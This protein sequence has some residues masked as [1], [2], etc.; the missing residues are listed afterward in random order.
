MVLVSTS[1][2]AVRSVPIHDMLLLNDF[3][4]VTIIIALLGEDA[5]SLTL[6][7]TP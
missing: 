3:L 1:S 4:D 2:T 5:Q 6:C 7:S